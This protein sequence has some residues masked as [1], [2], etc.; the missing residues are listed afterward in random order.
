[1]QD[2][3]FGPVRNAYGDRA[4]VLTTV[5]KLKRNMQSFPGPAATRSLA[6]AYARTRNDV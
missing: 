3:A 6:V 2:G 4:E 1:M 5:T